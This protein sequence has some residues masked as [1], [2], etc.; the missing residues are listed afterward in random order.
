MKTILLLIDEGNLQ[1]ALCRLLERHGFQILE[2]GDAE[3]A[4]CL[5]HGNQGQIDLVIADVCLPVGSGAQVALTLRTYLPE[6]AVVLAAGYP[7]EKWK[8]RDYALLGRLGSNSLAIL[9]KPLS[10]QTLLAEIAK[11]IGGGRIGVARTA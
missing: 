1:G 11:L 6:L 7:S 8:A 9:R 5:F 4:L 3:D 10:P 2:A